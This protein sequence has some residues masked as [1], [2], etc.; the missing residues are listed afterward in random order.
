M[1]PTR[2]RLLLVLAALAAVIGWCTVQLYGSLFGQ[3]LPVS[4]TAAVTMF[5]LALAIFIWAL[6]IRPRIK[7]KQGTRPISP[8]IA[9]RTAALAM[10]AS[11]TGA[12]VAGFYLGVAVELLNRFDVPATR[13]RLWFSLATVVASILVV[14]AALWLEHIC[15]LTE[16]EDDNK[17]PRGIPDEQSADWVHPRQLG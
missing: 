6:L 14:M 2:L 17:N 10:A 13:Q 7:R 3:T 15:R 12:L 5:V 4:W 1:T 16:G 8:F 9:A 11:R